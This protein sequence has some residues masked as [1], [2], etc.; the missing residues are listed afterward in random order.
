MRS[1]RVRKRRH[2][3]GYT[4]VYTA[5]NAQGVALRGSYALSVAYTE[6]TLYAIDAA[7]DLG[8][9]LGT[10]VSFLETYEGEQGVIKIA[11]DGTWNDEWLWLL[12]GGNIPFVR[13]YYEGYDTL[14]LRVRADGAFTFRI[15]AENQKEGDV[16][17]EL[18]SRTVT[19]TGEWQ[20][21][22]LDFA[23]FYEHWDAFVDHFMIWSDNNADGAALYIAS[24]TVEKSTENAGGELFEET[25]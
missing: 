12:R 10:Y 20:D 22:T 11:S 24:I 16:Q 3:S 25:T 6:N 23:Y 2:R 13:E 15:L 5:L 7:N 9:H 21:I 1:G 17:I 18:E 4:V 19:D 8:N 14:V